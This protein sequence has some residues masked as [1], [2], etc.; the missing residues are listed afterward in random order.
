M[1]NLHVAYPLSKYYTTLYTYLI[2]IYHKETL[3]YRIY[4]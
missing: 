4:I 1:N 3:K 2:L